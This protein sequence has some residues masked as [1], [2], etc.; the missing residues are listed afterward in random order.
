MKKEAPHFMNKKHTP[1]NARGSKT[2]D[3]KR[4]IVFYE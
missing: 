2:S 3:E 4:D 1:K